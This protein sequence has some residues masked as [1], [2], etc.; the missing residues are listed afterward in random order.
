MGPAAGQSR[1]PPGG[2]DPLGRFEILGAWLGIWTP[3]RNAVVPPLPKRKAAALAAGVAL[4]LAGAAVVLVPRIERSKRHEARVEQRQAAA[5]A[6]AERLR[7]A[8]DQALHS[9]HPARPRGLADSVAEAR[10]VRDLE[11]SIT[12]DAR[13]RIAAG[14]LA[15][16]IVS[17]TC[18]P[19]TR[20]ASP[21]GKYECT[22]AARAIPRSAGNVP[23]VLGYPFWARVDVARFA[24]VWCK[25]NPQ[26]GERGIGGSLGRV[27][28]PRRCDLRR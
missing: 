18:R 21:A 25:I 5:Q 3:P 6:A 8:R 14:T 11:G 13:A 24:Y 23:G 20:T 27:V 4:V 26:P 15:G 10:L 12:A 17:T 7:L 19:F 1:R 28:L 9:A 22:V 16:S 2:A